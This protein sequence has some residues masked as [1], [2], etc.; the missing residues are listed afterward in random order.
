LQVFK[1]HVSS[2]SSAFRRMLTVL[3]LDVSKV[4]RVFASPSSLAIACLG[5]SSSSRHWVRHP[6]S[7]PPLLDDGKV[8]DGACPA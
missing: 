7:P 2:V 3:H 1:M 4:D 8:R 5:V 6:S